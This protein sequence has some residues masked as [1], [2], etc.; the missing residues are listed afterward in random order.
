VVTSSSSA[1]SEPVDVEGEHRV[2]VCVFWPAPLLTI[3]IESTAD[4]GEELHLHPGGQGFW[5]ARMTRVLGADV[6]VCAPFGGETGVVLRHLLD[7]MSV[8][9]RAISTPAASGAYIHD[10][11]SSERREIWE[12]EHGV[13]GRHELDELYSATLAEGLAAGVCVLAGTNR[14]ETVEAVTYR[15]LAGDLGANG[16]RV[17]SD[18]SGH[19]L[20]AALEGSPYLV[21][22]SDEELVR[23]GFAADDGEEAV[24]EGIESLL[25]RG[26]ANVVLSRA[27][28]G[29][30]AVLDG[31]WYEVKA[32]SLEAVDPR[33][34]GDS[35]TAA[36][37]VSAARDL[38]AESSLRLAAAAAALN[39][40]RHGLGSG[41]ADAIA[42]LTANVD[43]RPLGERARR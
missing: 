14:F 12:G 26:A 18:L 4:S 28:K 11:R 9:V 10:R 7:E 33:G 24:V 8:R 17:I 19:E 13:L 2:A 35:M 39:V 5:V 29:S 30:I 36:L 1:E 32:P 15:R 34:A 23:G 21:K 22:L 41:R 16:V 25:A 40:T 43:V 31:T 27:D 6:V 38:D 20:A 37:A 42:Q 3:T